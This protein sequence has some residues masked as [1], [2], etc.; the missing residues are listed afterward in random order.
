L[1][2]T[3][4]GALYVAKDPEANTS[5][6]SM[7]SDGSNRAVVIPTGVNYDNFDVTESGIY[8]A[9]KCGENLGYAVCFYGFS[10]HTTQRLIS[11]K[12]DVYAGLSVD[13]GR[14]SVLFTLWNDSGSDLLA[15]DNFRL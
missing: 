13:T 7:K 14:R 6:W 10:S 15:V 2:A 12:A 8:F 4:G 5:I 3:D 9:G 1:E 11:L